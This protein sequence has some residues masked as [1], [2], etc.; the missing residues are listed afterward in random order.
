MLAN[1]DILEIRENIYLQ[2]WLPLK[3]TKIT[4]DIDCI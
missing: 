4:S 2:K 3:Y 1:K